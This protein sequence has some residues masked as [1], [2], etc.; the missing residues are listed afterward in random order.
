MKEEKCA[1]EKNQSWEVVDKPQ[2]RKVVDA[3]GFTH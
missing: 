3:S 1:L 2:A